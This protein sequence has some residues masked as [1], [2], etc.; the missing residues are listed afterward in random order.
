MTTFFPVFYIIALAVFAVGM[1]VT[2]T[3]WRK[4]PNKCTIPFATLGL[5]FSL[6]L[7]GVQLAG[8]AKP[9]EYT[10]AELGQI[11]GVRFDV[12][13]SY[14][15]QITPLWALAGFLVGF[16]ILFLGFA[17][18]GVGGGDVKL[19]AAL[20]IWLGVK[21]FLLVF[22]VAILLGAV[23]SVCAIIAKGPM[24]MIRRMNN[25]KKIG[26]KEEPEKKQTKKERRRRDNPKQLKRIIPFAIPVALS[27]GFFLVLFITNT[28]QS[29]PV[30]YR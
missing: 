4:I 14:L 29:I 21:W 17:I 28:F 25:L 1:A 24:R 9:L 18:G 8:I 15:C 23:L 12:M 20:G 16:F 13:F 3:V 6:A 27:V 11:E 10:A 26:A 22:C 30:F 5:I 2:D 7:W 19:L